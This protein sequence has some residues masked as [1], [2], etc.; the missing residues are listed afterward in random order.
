[1]RRV[2]SALVL[3]VLLPLPAL[4]S[5]FLN[6][7]RIDGLTNQTFDKVSSVRLDDQG[8]V[9]IVAPGYTV[10]T[11]EVPAP[12]APAP[13]PPPVAPAPVA[14]APTAAPVAP[15]APPAPAAPTRIT[16]RYWLVTEQSAQGKTEYDI[17]LFINSAWVRKLRNGE[18]Q[19]ITE[20]TRYL[21]PGRNTVRLMASKVVTGP[22][23]SQS[24]EHVFQVVIGEGNEGGGRVMLDK[25]LIRFQRTAAQTEDVTEEFI[26]TTR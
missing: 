21:R 15:A 2:I 1:M 8:N 11:M 22:R 14:P 10:K 23:R 6:G 25:P 24:A 5:V 13:T 16:Q 18:G 9:H 4:A 26:L 17:D 7:V 19:V 20:L 12:V 3:S